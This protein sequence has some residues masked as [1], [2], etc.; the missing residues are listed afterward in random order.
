MK[1][2][3]LSAVL[4]LLTALWLPP[5]AALAAGGAAAPFQPA[6]QNIMR[7]ALDSANGLFVDVDGDG[8]PELLAAY[9]TDRNVRGAVLI[10]LKDGRPQYLVN[11]DSVVLSRDLEF[12]CEDYSSINVVRFGSDVQIMAVRQRYYPDV[13]D[14][15]FGQLYWETGEFWLFDYAAGSVRQTDHWSYRFHEVADGRYFN[16]ETEVKHNGMLKLK[17]Q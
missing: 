17:L 10:A 9:Q 5:F 12:F 13:A 14:E 1:K 11:T 4:A 6:I 15:E 16:G 8:V 2:R 3:I 7:N